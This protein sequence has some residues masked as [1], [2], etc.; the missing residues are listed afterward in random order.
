MREKSRKP[1]KR[2]LHNQVH[3]RIWQYETLLDQVRT[4]SD[5]RRLPTSEVIG[6]E[7]ARAEML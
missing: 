2:C 5:R 6:A 4:T 7:Y 1:E 3:C